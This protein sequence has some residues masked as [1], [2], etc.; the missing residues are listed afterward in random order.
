MQSKDAPAGGG[1]QI[2]Q[3]L[4]GRYRIEALL[5]AGGMGKVYRAT[6]EQLGKRFAIKTLETDIK[7]SE[8]AELVERVARGAPAAPAIRHENVVVINDV[9]QTN[10]G[11][12]VVIVRREG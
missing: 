1:L 8:R 3:L 11:G 4:D 2:G 6:C 10:Q 9:G 7:V 12:E 5:G